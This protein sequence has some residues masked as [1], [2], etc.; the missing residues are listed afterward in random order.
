MHIEFD[1]RTCGET[2]IPSR[3]DLLQGPAFYRWCPRHRPGVNLSPI[4][5]NQT[6]TEQT[7]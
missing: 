6:G 7:G 3:R 4:P 2:Y 1:C 5:P